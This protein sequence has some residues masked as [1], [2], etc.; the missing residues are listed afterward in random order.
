M[1]GA[2]TEGIR[3]AM[4]LAAVDD[5]IVVLAVHVRTNGADNVDKAVIR[6]RI[7]VA[8]RRMILIAR[9]WCSATTRPPG[10][11]DVAPPTNAMSEHPIDRLSIAPK[12][13]HGY[14]CGMLARSIA[15]L[16]IVTLGARIELHGLG[17]LR[18]GGPLLSSRRDQRGTAPSVWRRRRGTLAALCNRSV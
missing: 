6:R 7:A 15:G 11:H 2:V 12:P 5:K 4:N 3:C 18:A 9:S 17:R 16:P 10:S 13:G 8:S 1:P 14:S